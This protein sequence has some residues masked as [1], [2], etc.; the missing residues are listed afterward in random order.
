MPSKPVIIATREFGSQGEATQFFKAMLNR[1]GPGQK[2]SDLDFL[3]LSALLER[4]PEYA[5]K[6]GAGVGHFEVVMTEHGTQC[7]RVVRTDGSGTDFSYLTCVRGRPPSR[8]TEVASGFRQAVRIDLF[9]AR[10]QF[11]ADHKDAEGL[12][13]CAVTGERLKPHEGHMDH[14]A[15]L[16]F[17]VIVTTFLAARR[18]RS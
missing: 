3:D 18:P 15:P 16:T 11:F 14:R 13:V 10:D 2:V 17:E 1:Y 5:N 7:F 12:V 6:V 4:H 8:K 9:R